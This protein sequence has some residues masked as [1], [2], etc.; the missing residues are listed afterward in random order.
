LIPNGLILERIC[1]N[2]CGRDVIVD[3]PWP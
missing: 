3:W 2:E 1:C